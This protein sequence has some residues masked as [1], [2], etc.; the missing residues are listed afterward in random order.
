V[1]LFALLVALAGAGCGTEDG[2]GI[3]DVSGEEET[4]AHDQ[5]ADPESVVFPELVGDGVPLELRPFDGLVDIRL[6][7]GE[8]GWPCAGPDDCNSGYCIMTGEKKICTT[9]C[10]SEC[11]DGYVCAPVSNTPPD[12]TYV[13]LPRFDK[14]CQPCL[15]HKDC[16]P[17]WGAGTDLCLDYGAE[18]GFCGAECEDGTC[19]AGYDCVVESAPDG[20]KVHQ[21]RLSNGLCECTALSKYLQLSTDC[22]VENEHGKCTGMRSCEAAG[23]GVCDAET[24]AEE[25]C[26]SAD[27]DCNGETDDI[28]ETACLVQNEFGDCPGTAQCVLGEEICQGP[29][30]V[31]E[32]CDGKDNDCNGFTDEGFQDTDGNQEADCVD[33]DDDGDGV[34]DEQDNCPLKENGD[35]ANFDG[36]EKGDV[37]DNDDDD[38]GAPDAGDCAPLDPEV[39]PF[40]PEVC[41]GLDNDCDGPIDEGSC[42]D[43]NLCTDDVCDVAMGCQHPFNS[44][45]C[46]DGN[47]C[48]ENDHCAFGECAGSFI[49][50]DDG[51]PCTANS[52]DPL[53]GCTFTYVGGACDDGNPCTINDICSQGA[54]A[55]TPSGCEC[56]SDIDCKQF[57]DGNSCNGTLKC[58]KE[59][60]PYKCVVDPLTIVKCQLPPGADPACA[61][62][63]C[64]PNTGMCDAVPANEGLVCNDDNLCTIN[65]VCTAGACIGLPKNCSDANQ[66][67]DDVCDPQGGCQHSYNTDPCDDGNP[68]TI[69][70]V[71]QGGTCVGGGPLP[72]NDNNPC[73]NDSCLA[74]QGCVHVNNALPCDDGNA[75]T[76]GDLCSAGLCTGGLPVDCDDKNVCTNDLCDPTSGCKYAYNQAP[77]DDGN[78]CTAGDLCQG[79]ACV[80]GVQLACDDFNP[81]TTDSCEAGVGCVHKL[82]SNPCNDGNAC[83]KNDLCTNGVC[84]G[85]AVACDDANPC[86]SDACDA[87][88]GCT[89]APVSGP[90]DDGDPCTVG[91]TCQLGQCQSGNQINCDDDDQCTNDQCAP[92]GSCKHV[93]LNG[94]N[95]D[96]G[97]ECTVNDL[98]VNGECIGEGN[99]SCCLKD[100]DCNDDNSC[101]KDTCVVETG[102]CISQAGPMNGLACNADSSGCTAGDFCEGGQCFVGQK[103]DC[104]DFVDQCNNAECQST[105]IQT[106][107]CSKIPLKKGTDCDDKQ[108]C[109]VDDA[110]DGAGNC[111]GG[112]QLDCSQFT[113]GCV[114]GACNEQTDQCQGAPLPDG[115]PCNADDNGCTV[116]D[117]CVEG[118]CEPGLSAD[119]SWLSSPCIVG[120]CKPAGADDPEGYECESQ[121][122]PQNTECDD[123]LFCTIDDVCDGA[124]WCGSGGDNPCKEAEDDCNDGH[125]DE[126]GDKCVPL[127]KED[128]VSCNDGDACTID[129][130]C[131]SGICT[132]SSNVCGEYKVSTFKTAQGGYAPA[133]ADHQDGRFAIFWNSLSQ[134]TG[135]SYTDSWSKEGTEFQLMSGGS[136]HTEVDAAGFS[137]GSVVVGMAYRTKSTSNCSYNYNCGHP[138]K[139]C[140]LQKK[141][142]KLLMHW[143]GPLNKLI[144]TQ[145]VVNSNLTAWLVSPYE[146]TVGL[147][148]VASFPNGNSIIVR[149]NGSSVT[150]RIYTPDGAGLAVNLGTLGTN[151]DS[152]DVATHKDDAFIVVWSQAG[153]LYGQ[154]YTQAG[155]KDGTQ[156]TVSEAASNQ[157]KPSVETYYNGRFVVAW[158]SDEDGTKDI[159]CRVFK[160][161]G[162]PVAPNEVL[163]NTTDNGH[164]KTPDV[165]VF[166]LAGNFVVTWEGTDPAGA[167]IFAQYFNKNASP[168]GNEKIVN[169]KTDGSQTSPTVKVLSNS[170]AVFSWRGTSGQVWARKYDS[171]GNA[172]THSAEIVHNEVL[173]NE[174]SAPDGAAQ[175]DG[176]YVVAWE[177]ADAENDIDI[178]A[179]RFDLTGEPL[180]DEFTLNKTSEG[181]QNHPSIGTDSA[182]KFVAVWQSFG[183]D[184]DVEGVYA[185]RF[186][187]DG[188]PLSDE[189]QVNTT[190]DYE[191]Y[192]P[193][194]AVDR[195]PGFDGAFGVVWTSFLQENGEDYDI[196]GRCF[197]ANNSPLGE[198]FMVNA[199]VDNDQVAPGI[200]YIPAGPSRYIAVWAS[201]NQDGDHYGI[202]AQ[203]LTPTCTK[204][205]S[206]FL[207]NTTTAKE[208]SQPAVAAAS[209]GSFAVV[210]RS[211]NQDGDSYGI[212]AQLF[213]NAGNKVGSEFKVNRV[214]AKEQSSP[215]IGFLS[216]G[217]LLAGWKTLGEDEVG[218]AVK[219]QYLDADGALNGLDFL[220]NIYYGANQDEPAIVALP[221][222]GNL[223]LWRSNGQDGS[224]GAIVGRLLP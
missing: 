224:G 41:D 85:E 74:G 5:A 19:P 64:N 192:E 145:T 180:G 140:C 31:K 158:E 112:G 11:P 137:D 45:P 90:C 162:N 183:Q 174:Q 50:C 23:L 46:T 56:N 213:D 9:T 186:D 160:K 104:S 10:V 177:S 189:V 12:V 111:L 49:D 120:A 144:K 156:I 71:C 185:R 173:A 222:K 2:T 55:G 131:K 124:G 122:K 142:E 204:Q 119:C 218:S 208:Q 97:N 40:A 118:N 136:Y 217:A 105:G 28:S 146:Y 1:L 7:E 76:K 92:D 20:T 201:K 89:F 152:F 81:C 157:T 14:L 114:D 168:V 32:V 143:Y 100:S 33:P 125:C 61:K 181:W 17:I 26:N 29:S 44:D 127:P 176:G 148:K 129:D 42:D 163:V 43:G 175:A 99:P 212:Y 223:M 101:T 182:G 69:G 80:G 57:E 60:A 62:A 165:A 188:T 187:T 35:Q 95:C 15:E 154:L 220:G 73:T 194:I 18:G 202:Y 179:R 161:D 166:D 4:A 94:L 172:L 3:P 59:A 75:C 195:S 198:E 205:A 197:S 159:R 139:Y 67:T 147:L 196:M 113:G 98:C 13:C 110:C 103:V 82:N 193:M 88:Q 38:D 25:V 170:D 68:C 77:C 169:V 141:E 48:T 121:F 66:C 211:F 84:V 190:T 191:Q 8:F 149:H 79:G 24:P 72:C 39:Y 164:E 21:C 34:M 58:D 54:C 86:T 221:E 102:Q 123:G 107:K 109:T 130:I 126:A 219:F 51:N 184:G 210:W 53:V 209:D 87:Q 151:W 83:T 106:Y 132:G 135:R 216:D 16:Q 153:N 27:D 36:D 91:D 206:P 63:Q 171:Q 96:D 37:C 214:T 52:C 117:S 6:V 70:D 116:G 30:A 200:A 115:T 78:K 128:G 22:F 150:G 134:F 199:Y 167:G 215:T 155:T 207:V 203:R 133:I 138:K 178:K 47:P 93:E 108:F 65:E